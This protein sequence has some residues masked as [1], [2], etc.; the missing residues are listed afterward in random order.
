MSNRPIAACW[1]LSWL[2][3]LV[4]TSVGCGDDAKRMTCAEPACDDEVVHQDVGEVVEPPD[5]EVSRVS[6]ELN[7][8][9]TTFDTF[10]GSDYTLGGTPPMRFVIT[11]RKGNRSLEIAIAPVEA[12]PLGRWRES[13]V[14]EATVQICYDDGIS[15]SSDISLADCPDGFSHQAVAYDLTLTAN[16]GVGEFTRGQ[17]T[18]TLAN[19]FDQRVFITGGAIDVRQR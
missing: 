3:V 18:A 16:P 8:S 10:A 12:S 7:G 2:V 4:S 19:P 11:A 1:T 9:A 17:F 14:G 5:D 15:A 13:D 6:F